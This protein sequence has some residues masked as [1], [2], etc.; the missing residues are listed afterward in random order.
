MVACTSVVIADIPSAKVVAADIPTATIVV[1]T[2]VPI[3]AG[4]ACC[5][6]DRA[7]ACSPDGTYTE[8]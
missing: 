2:K 8:S 6:V 3:A 5:D 4:A 7:I 1:I